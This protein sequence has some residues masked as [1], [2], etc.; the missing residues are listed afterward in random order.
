MR[1]EWLRTL[2]VFVLA[3][4]VFIGFRYFGRDTEPAPQPE[5][6]VT[7]T[8]LQEETTEEPTTEATTEAAG[9]ETT[10]EQTDP[11]AEE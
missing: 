7:T 10:A 6:T 5:E 9:T 4:V 11:S 2:P 1:R 3:A 8:Q